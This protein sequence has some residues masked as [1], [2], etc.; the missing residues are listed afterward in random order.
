MELVD[1]GVVPVLLWRPNV[2]DS[3]TPESVTGHGA[4]ARKP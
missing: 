4:V 1:P 2:T 3:G